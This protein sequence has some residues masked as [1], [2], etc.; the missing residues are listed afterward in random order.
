[1]RYGS[2][3]KNHQKK[4]KYTHT[5]NTP[6]TAT[7]SRL[8]FISHHIGRVET[9]EKWTKIAIDYN[10]IEFTN[11]SLTNDI[12]VFIV[13]SQIYVLYFSLSLS[14][15]I[16]RWR[17]KNIFICI[18]FCCCWCFFFPFAYLEYNFYWHICPCCVLMCIKRYGLLTC[19]NEWVCRMLRVCA[20]VVWVS[21]VNIMSLIFMFCRERNWKRIVIITTWC[22]VISLPSCLLMNITDI[23]ISIA[24]IRVRVFNS[25]CAIIW[26]LHTHTLSKKES[27]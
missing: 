21:F 14:L 16:F 17:A 24:N 15:F 1:M 11:D 27:K 23:L 4:Q 10:W 25:I 8:C 18:Y 12:V 19:S 22:V 20:F 6:A 3:N 13:N 5:K 2:P 7:A 9:L 26:L